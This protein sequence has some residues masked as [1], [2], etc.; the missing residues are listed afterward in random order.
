MRTR[1]QELV[2]DDLKPLVSELIKT[3]REK[4]NY[5]LEDLS[6]ITTISV[7]INEEPTFLEHNY[8]LKCV[9]INSCMYVKNK[10]IGNILTTCYILI[11]SNSHNH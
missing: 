2:S 4:Y 1:K 11:M 7:S 5:S 3:A 8:D 9:I 6:W 10:H